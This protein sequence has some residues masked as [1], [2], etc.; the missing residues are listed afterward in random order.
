M[1]TLKT[2]QQ[3]ALDVLAA[4]CQQ[5]A[6]T[7]DPDLAFY[8]ITRQ[9]FHQGIAYRAVAELPGLPYVCIRIPTGGG[10]TLVAA[11]S[12]GILA[13]EFLH[14]DRPL[15]LWLTPSN[16][17]RSQTLATLRNRQ[18]PYRQALEQ[19]FGT[20]NVL[21]VDEA[22]FLQRV[23]LDSGATILVATMQAFRVE[24]TDGRK[25]YEDN[26]SLMSHFDALPAAALADLELFD[27]GQPLRS[28]A[29]VL[30]LRRPIVVVDEAH[31]AR[32]E[33]SFTTLARF[34]PAC[35]VEFTATP[36]AGD[37]GSNVLYSVSAAE[38]K[39][40]SMIKLPIRLSTH[41]YWKE[42]LHAAINLR[43]RLE[44]LAE[45]ERLAGGAYL[46]PIMLLQA[47]KTF[48]HR[49]TI[50]VDAL[51]QAL[52]EEF[53][54]P[55]EQ[56]ARATGAERGI[57]GID[58]LDR[59]CPI[60]FI[61][62]VQA[63]REGWDCPFAYVL[64]SVAEMHSGPAVEQMTG[65]ILRM[66]YAM[67][68]A[69]AELNLAYAFTTSNN[70]A[71]AL[72]ALR[73]ALVENGFE[74]QS[75]ADFIE[76]GAAPITDTDNLPLW[77][78]A[79]DNAAD[80]A[81][82]AAPTQAA[83]VVSAAPQLGGLPLE[84]SSLLRY[85]PARNELKYIGERMDLAQMQALQGAFPRSDDR[86]AVQRLFERVNRSVDR[87]TPSQ[88]AAPFAV[89]LLVFHQGEL[90]EP[91]EELHLL[92]RLPVSLHDCTPLLSP[93][94][95][96]P[97]TLGVQSGLVD[98][99]ASGHVQ[100]EGFVGDLHRQMTYLDADRAWSEADLV[101]WLD[102]R[103]PKR[104]DLS[105]PESQRYLT[106]L[107]VNVVG[108]RSIPLEVLVRDRHRLLS[109]VVKKLADCRAEQ[110][111]QVFQALLLDESV[112]AGRLEVSDEHTIVFDPDNY[113]YNQLYTGRLSLP[114]TTTR[115]WAT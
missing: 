26:G 114:I 50:N 109:A 4:Y 92:E 19:R 7:G 106:R 89:P 59:A 18:H 21:D 11:H 97:V 31:N 10:K 75:A 61:I 79:T 33:L 57:E 3:N 95:Y 47:D 110:R 58:L 49:Q 66:P 9:H 32:T 85:D 103:L 62:T 72:N 14:S 63:L 102:G 27:N 25:V 30:R 91:F 82:S 44:N 93:A 13:Q 108:D 104:A 28:L 39:A 67:R 90:I 60:R 45:Q 87:R 76:R 53:N 8:T 65:R 112:A 77:Q 6:I 101:R 88:R 37:H 51:E 35:I 34:R 22:R 15:V 69:A 41:A 81:T 113:A 71:G 17:I 80:A 84:L 43:Q 55:A 54:I 68:R 83:V 46:R 100:A 70:F 78:A 96:T 98:V 73:D 5:C 16:A 94:E 86:T 40:E 2:Y 29:N 38:L 107:L 12:A 36:A 23:T 20:V 105:L 74:R 52:R 111:V 99:T 56:I 42:L 24:E 48:Q 1:L 64:F 115:A